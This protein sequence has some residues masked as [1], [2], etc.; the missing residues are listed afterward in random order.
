M[1]PKFKSRAAWP[2]SHSLS[3]I[4]RGNEVREDGGVLG[5]LVKQSIFA[6]EEISYLLVLSSYLLCPSQIPIRHTRNP[7]DSL[8]KTHSLPPNLHQISCLRT[9]LAVLKGNFRV[10]FFLYFFSLKSLTYEKS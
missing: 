1:K 6:T 2:M 4:S 7:E 8:G 9:A 3:T 5:S 10:L